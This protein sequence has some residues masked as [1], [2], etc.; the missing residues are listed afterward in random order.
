VHCW[1][2]RVLARESQEAIE[3]MRL[4][5]G[6]Y[7][8]A[9][10][11]QQRPAPRGGGLIQKGWFKT[12]A[13]EDLP[14]KFESMLQS[15]DTANKESDLADF[16]VCT[17]W[18]IKDKG[19]YLLNVLRKRMDYPTLKCAV[20]EQAMA[21][22]PDVILIEDKASGTQLIQELH[23][24]G[25]RGITGCKPGAGGKVMRM[26]AETGTIQA[27]QVYLPAEASWLPEYLHEMVV[28]PNGRYD[29]QVD[30]T[31]QAL[32]WIKQ[33]QWAPNMGLFN[34]MREQYEAQRDSRLS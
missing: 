32:N 12:Y 27:G 11:Y 5:M 14:K 17:T 23:F 4:T 30:S 16:T 26:S 2:V 34:Y 15:W 1:A 18:G 28:F 13:A 6:E 9:G 3:R 33:R 10:Q 19:I 20:I 7:H 8:F 21:Y 29:D 25:V 22:R 31:A 24:E